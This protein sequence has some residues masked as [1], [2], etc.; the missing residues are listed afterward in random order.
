MDQAGEHGG[1]GRGAG[2]PTTSF[3]MTIPF[4]PPLALLASAALFLAGAASRLSAQMTFTPGDIILGFQATGGDGSSNTYVYNLG[5]GTGFRDGTATGLIATIGTD[6][7]NTFGLGWFNRSDLYWGIA[8]VRDPAAG[9]PNTVV[10]GDAKATIYVSRI[11]AAGAGTSTPWVLASGPTV[12]SAATSVATMQFG[13]NTTNG[14]DV[15]TPETQRTP[16]PGSNG[17]GTV[18]GTGDINNW[19]VFNPVGGPAFGNV[20]TGGV[21]A[22]LGGSGAQTWLDLYRIMGRASAAATPNTPLGQ[23]LLVGSFSITAAGE[24]NYQVSAP[25][26]DPFASW[27]DANGL[28]GAD[29]EFEA[30]PD[31]DGL[32]NGVE[33]VVAG[34]PK[35]PTDADK[36]PTLSRDGDTVVFVFRRA[37]AATD[38]S[39]A[40]QFTTTPFGAWTIAVNG[41]AGVTVA[42]DNDGFVAG[43]DRVTVRIPWSPAVSP[44]VYARLAVSPAP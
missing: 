13:F 32:E 18:Q 9:G 23:G 7:T 11:A 29:R 10:N 24:I 40:A 8:G 12:I 1:A 42:T 15:I 27:A 4:T 33:F 2:V 26:T 25:P 43:V 34:N 44:S 38:L 41:V 14:S 22:P 20:L 35:L 5:A 21:Q 39:P 31:R 19:S 6:L 17:R 16:T 36:A 37:D 30:D 3:T 28:T